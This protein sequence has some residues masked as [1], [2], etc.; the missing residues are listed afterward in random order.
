M[1][2]Q[3]EAIAQLTSPDAIAETVPCGPDAARAAEVIA[4]YVEAGFD[5]IY[6]A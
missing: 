3:D 5:E 1:W 2:L 4:K 6:I